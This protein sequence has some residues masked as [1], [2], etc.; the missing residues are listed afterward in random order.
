MPLA[1]SLR[2]VSMYD[3]RHDDRTRCVRVVC[4]MK[5]ASQLTY[6]VR[7]RGVANPGVGREQRTVPLKSTPAGGVGYSTV[8]LYAPAGSRRSRSLTL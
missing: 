8:Q 4:V 7:L 5:C 2:C 6:M 3:E 1:E